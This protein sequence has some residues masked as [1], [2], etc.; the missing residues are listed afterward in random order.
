MGDGHDTASS[1]TLDEVL[2]LAQRSLVTIYAV[3]TQAF[4]F[5]NVT[6]DVLERLTTETRG[7][8]RVSPGLAL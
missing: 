7:A 1:K 5:A 4:G 6:K 2:E 8:C 3:S